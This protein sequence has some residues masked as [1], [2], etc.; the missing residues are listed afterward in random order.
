MRKR[1]RNLLRSGWHEVQLTRSNLWKWQ[2][3]N[4]RED[5]GDDAYYRHIRTWCND[6]FA[7]D[8]WEGKLLRDDWW[9]DSSGSI[10]TKR[11]IFK[12]EKDKLM[13]VLKWQ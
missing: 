6:T 4:S 13:F 10:I 8:T 12:N 1:F 3:A 7:K 11:F 5:W 2:E 9:K